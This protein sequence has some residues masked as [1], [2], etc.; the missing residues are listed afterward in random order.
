MGE[1]MLELEIG[2]CLLVHNIHC[3]R[4]LAVTLMNLL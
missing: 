4:R 1:K 2:D 3:P